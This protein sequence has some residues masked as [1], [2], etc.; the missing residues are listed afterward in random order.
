MARFEINTDTSHC[1]ACSPQNEYGLHLSFEF[2]GEICRTRFVPQE[3]YQGWTGFTHG[4]ILAT[5]LDETMAQW[6]WHKD[7][8]AMTAEMEVRFIKAVP[9]GREV[10]V[11]AACRRG[12][13]H[14][15]YLLEAG[16]TMDGEPVARAKAKF[17]ATENSG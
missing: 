15:L 11:T 10:V 7:I 6:L 12:P 3:R 5:V 16:M 13:S 17:M 4:G 8:V 14:G 1:F 9:V 2:E